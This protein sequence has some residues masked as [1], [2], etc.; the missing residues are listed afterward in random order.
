MAHVIHVVTECMPPV[1]GVRLLLQRLNRVS[2][3]IGSSF[4]VSIVVY[5]SFLK[6]SRIL[7]FNP[8]GEPLTFSQFVRE[9]RKKFV[10]VC[11]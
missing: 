9:M 3:G 1:S 7:T 6:F 10:S 2:G 8:A 4:E 11:H 5:F